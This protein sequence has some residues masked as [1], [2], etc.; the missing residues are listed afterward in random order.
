MGNGFTIGCGIL[1]VSYELRVANCVM[2][3][4][5]GGFYSGLRPLPFPPVDAWCVRFNA[6]KASKPRVVLIAQ[7]NNL[8]NAD[9]VVHE[10]SQNNEAKQKALLAEIGCSLAQM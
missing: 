6:A 3:I 10:I 8:Y 1:G 5:Q 2:V 9:W 7:D 4:Y